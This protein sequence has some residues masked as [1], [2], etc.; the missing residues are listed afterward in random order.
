MVR[1]IGLA[2]LG[3]ALS[4]CMNGGA[5]LPGDD[6]PD[7]R[8]PAQ[9]QVMSK[10]FT[11][12]GPRGYCVDPGATRDSAEGAFAI[13]GSC[14]VISGNPRDATPATPAILTAS[15][16]PATGPL[17][18]AALDRLTAFFST[19]AGRAALARADDAGDV[20]LIDLDRDDGL[21]LVHAQDGDDSG[22]VAGDYWRA[23]FATAGQLVTV[24]V[25][26]F[27]EAPLDDKTG[28]A[29]AR[30]FVKAIRR[31]NPAGSPVAGADAATE[32]IGERLT[33]F[34]NRL[35]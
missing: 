5:G 4:G 26:G 19:G 27:R 12:A 24:T 33:S 23:V 9:V 8:A 16:T 14:A 13:L 17:D 34:F 1:G 22:D 2:L 6:G 30:G 32:G 20:T 28:A 7:V 31:A 11:I 3:V 29:L 35:P 18:D 15:V 21:V 25:S 10:A